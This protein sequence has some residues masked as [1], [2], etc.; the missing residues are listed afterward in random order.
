MT[1]ETL[2]DIARDWLRV[3]EYVGV[4]DVDRFGRGRLLRAWTPTVT[5]DGPDPTG[6]R[7]FVTLSGPTNSEYRC[8]VPASSVAHVRY[9]TPPSQP[10]ISRGP[11]HNASLLGTLAAALED[12]LGTEAQVPIK[13]II[14]MPDSVSSAD[15]DA[16]KARIFDR[17]DLV[18]TP[19][20]TQADWG[21]DRGG[22][23][24]RDWQPQRLGPEFT[25]AE[26]T[27]HHRAFGAVL[28]ACGVPPILADPA[29]SAGGAREGFRQMLAGTVKPLGRLIAGEVGRVLERPVELHFDELVAGAGDVASRARA[30]QMMTEAGVD[31]DRAM[32]LAGL[33]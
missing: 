30:L 2:R 10:W 7:Y 29:A 27:M 24:Q 22:A 16:V 20:T 21:G 18:Q 25:E 4:F 6:W 9:S 13:Q 8:G 28:A 11:L 5:G 26:V 23:P 15:T 31:R 19:R 32:R 17:K 33:D 3:G 1:P 14:T 12:A